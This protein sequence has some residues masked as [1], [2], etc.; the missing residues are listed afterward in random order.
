MGHRMNS[1]LANFLLALV[2]LAVIALGWGGALMFAR[3][4]K[5]RG[6]LMLVAALVMLG[7][8]LI[9]TV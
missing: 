5:K 3:G 7:N 8:V 6:V 1:P 9:W 4:E 2:M